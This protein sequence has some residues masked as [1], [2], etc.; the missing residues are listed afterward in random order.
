MQIPQFTFNDRQDV[1][2]FFID[3]HDMLIELL[4]NG[5]KMG[6][7]DDLL[8]VPMARLIGPVGGAIIGIKR[9]QFDEALEKC[10]KHF[11]DKEEYEKC[12]EI[13]NML[14]Q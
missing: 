4:F 12:A 13:V 10:L 8:F 3:K 11:E 6:L 7:N 5:I 14:K 1:N 2:R 9:D